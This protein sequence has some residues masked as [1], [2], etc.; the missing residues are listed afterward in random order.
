MSNVQLSAVIYASSPKKNPDRLAE[1]I[2][3]CRSVALENGC[4]IS[5][6]FCDDEDIA[7][8]KRPGLQE[9]LALIEN[10]KGD[11]LVMTNAERLSSNFAD[12]IQIFVQV[13]QCHADIKLIEQP[14]LNDSIDAFEFGDDEYRSK[15]NSNVENFVITQKALSRHL[16]KNL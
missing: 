13:R 7:L 9:A 2:I 8:D 5:G 14:D 10:K 3:I 11:F 4:N 16:A 12:Y 15:I 6:V 1:Q